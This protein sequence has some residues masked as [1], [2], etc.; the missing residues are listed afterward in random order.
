MLVKWLLLL[1]IAGNF[2]NTRVSSIHTSVHLSIHH[3]SFN[4][5]STLIAL[6][7]GPS[8]ASVTNQTAP[9]PLGQRS[10]DCPG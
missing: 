7:C 3:P 10:M 1:G 9:N 5:F 8:G 2:T 6:C 4:S